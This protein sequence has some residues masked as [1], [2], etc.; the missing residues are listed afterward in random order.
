MRGTPI[1]E[2][3]HHQIAR[4]A[5]PHL[6]PFGKADFSHPRDVEVTML[7]WAAHMLRF[8]GGRFARDPRFR[9]WCFNTYMRQRAKKASKWYL[10]THPSERN[11]IVEDIRE[12]IDNGD[13]RQLAQRV[14]HAA[15]KLPGIS[16][17]LKYGL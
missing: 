5:F 2:Y 6:F 10:T 14:S 17:S 3:S 1:N 8:K 4:D 13:A 12:M 9:Y 16:L 11:F 15:D 7:E